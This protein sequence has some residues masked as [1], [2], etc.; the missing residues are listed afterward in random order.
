[1]IAKHSGKQLNQILMRKVSCLVKLCFQKN[2]LFW[3]T[4]RTFKITKTINLEPCKCSNTMNI[5]EIISTFD[6]HI[7]TKKI[8]KYFPNASNNN[9]E[10]TEVLIIKFKNKF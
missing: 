6:D 8:N 5:N 2:G 7:S 1:M 3:T 9:F 10:F 4:I